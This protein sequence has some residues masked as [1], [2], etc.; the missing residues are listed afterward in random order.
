MG[1][2][3]NSLRQLAET[4]VG[5][6]TDDP[7]L[8]VRQSETY[9]SATG[10]ASTTSTSVSLKTTPPLPV[11]YDQRRGDNAILSTD[12]V[13]FCASKDLDDAAFD[14][15]PATNARV[16]V[17]VAGREFQIVRVREFFSG[18]SRALTELICRS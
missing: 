12:V 18:D 6:F 15:I 1:L 9:D 4:I 2:L 7:A 8:F 11:E 17:T 14:P 13:V 10:V 5:L 16:Y 3:D